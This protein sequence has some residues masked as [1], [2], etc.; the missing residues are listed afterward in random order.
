MKKSIQSEEPAPSG[1]DAL[2]LI[3]GRCMG[4]RE[5]FGLVAGRCSAADI[6][7]LRQIREQK[8]YK[9]LGHSWAE[10]C[11][12]DLH[13]ARRSVDREIGYLEEFGPEFFHV[14]QMT[15]IS[16]KDYRA[17]ASYIT[18][19]GVHLNGTAVALLPENSPQVSAAVAELLK[20]IEPKERRPAAVPVSFDAAL[21]RCHTVTEM[22]GVMPEPLDVNQKLD[23]GA[24]IA[25][26][27]SAAAGLGVA[28]FDRR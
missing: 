4:R 13:V 17:I 8:L 9:Q 21:K 26:L 25:E 19:E 6:E 2:N 1:P 24:A 5:A 7:T 10:C 28:V 20:R 15:H 27:R 12:L 16:P 22:L 3:L 23:L 14:R 18:K 11:T